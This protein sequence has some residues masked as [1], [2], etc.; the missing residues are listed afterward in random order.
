MARNVAENEADLLRDLRGRIAR[1]LLQLADPKT[2]AVG[3]TQRELAEFVGTTRSAIIP[4]L[5]YFR[6]RGIITEVG[7]IVLLRRT[8]LQEEAR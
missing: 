5:T 2:G 7:P 4:H 6:Q 8:A 3:V 1:K